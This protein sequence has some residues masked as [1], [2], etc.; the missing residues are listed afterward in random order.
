MLHEN[1]CSG[2]ALSSVLTFTPPPNRT[3]PLVWSS[4]Q[5]Y[6]NM[7]PVESC[8]F[9]CAPCPLSPC[10]VSQNG[11]SFSRKGSQKETTQFGITLRSAH[12]MAMG[13]NPVPPVNIPILTKMAM[14]HTVCLHFGADEHHILTFIKV[15]RVLAHSQ[16][17]SKMGGAPTP[18]W[19]PQS[20][21]SGRLTRNAQATVTERFTPRRQCT[22]T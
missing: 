15:Y 18:K 12:I 8:H 6:C 22:S 7:A 10:G 20:C 1:G 11:E 2:Y 3:I 19:Y 17:G 4:T 9:R 14:G 21:F 5:K 13:Q 16:I